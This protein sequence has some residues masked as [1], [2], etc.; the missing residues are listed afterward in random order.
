MSIKKGVIESL[1]VGDTF[2]ITTND[3]T[4]NTY[5][6]V[7]HNNYE[8]STLDIICLDDKEYC[9]AVWDNFYADIDDV[10]DSLYVDMMD[11]LIIDIKKLD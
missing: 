6:I 10:H 11:G 7:P 8:G 9:D 2:T 3:K 5:K 1:N 4:C